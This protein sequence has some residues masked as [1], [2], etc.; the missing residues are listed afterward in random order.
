[1]ILASAQTK[2]KRGDIN[3]NLS[4]HYGLIKIAV[5]NGV[6]LIAFPEMS[7]TGYEREKAD[8]LAFSPHDARL[9]SLIKLAV[10]N[11][12]TIIAGAPVKINSDLFIGE[13]IIS[14]DSSVK[15]YTKQFLHPGEEVNFQ[16]SFDYNPLLKLEGE[17]ISLAI[18][19]D[20][21]N[22]LHPENANKAD[23]SIYI[24]SLFFSPKGI[25]SAHLNLSNYAKKYSM[26][27]LMANYSGNSWGQASGGRSAF[28]DTNGR[29]IAAM[30]D[31]ASGLLIAE[32]NKDTWTGK[33]LIDKR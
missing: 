16:P 19:A 1:M 13:F 20:I 7:I 2:P 23:T 14:P 24:A 32:K 8:S 6:D 28:W 30:D 33:I 4:D 25:P 11:K 5:D 29:L 26:N 27:V 3:A 12:I 9:D 18:C 17:K 10:E 15:I 31:S 22:P 21:D